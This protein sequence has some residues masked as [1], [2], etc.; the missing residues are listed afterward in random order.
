[1]NKDTHYKEKLEKIKND[2]RLLLEMARNSIA[3]NT[4][5]LGEQIHA[6][7][8]AIEYDEKQSC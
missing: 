3:E 7:L 1:M 2:H 4:N 6:I 5:I 8:N